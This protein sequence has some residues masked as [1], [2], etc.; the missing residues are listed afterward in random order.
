MASASSSLPKAVASSARQI[1]LENKSLRFIAG[2]WTFFIAENFV[3]SHNRTEIIDKIGD[4]GYHTVYNSLSSAACMSLGYGYYKLRNN[5]ANNLRLF[6]VTPSIFSASILATGTGCLLVSQLFP[7]FRNPADLMKNLS[8]KRENK[9]GLCPMDFE[10]DREMASKNGVNGVQRITRHASLYGLGFLGLGVALRS[11][12]AAQALL[13]GG[14][15]PV[16]GILANHIDHR[17]RNGIGGEIK[18]DWPQTSNFPFTAIAFGDQKVSD[19]LCD[20]KGTNAAAAGLV[21]LAVAW[22]RRGRIRF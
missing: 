9:K 4:G 12:L 19:V 16:V 18:Y 1:L 22:A 15:F 13:F 10:A 7:S 2:G 17:Y 21:T 6:K 14:L 5:A 8:T 11:G 3:L 20:L